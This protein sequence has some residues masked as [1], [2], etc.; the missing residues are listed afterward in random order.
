ME[1]EQPTL[2]ERISDSHRSSY[3]HAD[4]AAADARATCALVLA[5]GLGTR[6]KQ[7]TDLRSKPG[8]AFAGDLRL[9]DFTLANCM[10]SGI[11]HIGVLAQHWTPSLS[12]H[13][14]FHWS[15][16]ATGP[17]E[18]IDMLLPKG[19]GGNPDGAYSGTADAVFQNLAL[20]RAP[21]ARY[22]LALAGDHVYQMDYRAM[23]R[24]HMACGADVHAHHFPRSCVGTAGAQRY[25]RDV[26]TLD[27]Y[28]Q[29]H[30]VPCFLRMSGSVQEAS[31]KSRCCCL[32]SRSVATRSYAAR[33]SMRVVCFRTASR[34]D[35]T[36]T[37]T[38]DATPSLKPA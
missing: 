7:L 1:A 3:E 11:R 17:D 30:M 27:A 4:A 26:G 16:L 15:S 33:S 12:R 21:G 29:A 2:Q 23:L 9:I 32:G 14:T 25:W 20:A 35:S 5:G 6:L 37:R 19:H 8:V 10:N 13:V 18:F 28:W 36:R 38:V 22:M 34:S 24:D 31:S